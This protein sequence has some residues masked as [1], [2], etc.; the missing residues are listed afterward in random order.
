MQQHGLANAVGGGPE[1]WEK[2]YA[3]SMAR[4]GELQQED[5]YCTCEDLFHFL[6]SHNMWPDQETD[7][8]GAA[9]SSMPSLVVG[10]GTS[11]LPML[12]A[13]REA[14]HCRK[15]A[16]TAIDA[17]S[18]AIK[19]MKQADV[20]DLVDWRVA[21]A[22][23]MEDKWQHCFGMLFDKGLLGSIVAAEA[24]QAAGGEAAIEGGVSPMGLLKEYH[25]VLRP[26][27]RV[28][29][30][31]P[32]MHSQH[33]LEENLTSTSKSTTGGS[34]DWDMLCSRAIGDGVVT[35]ARAVFDF[36]K[37][38]E[39]SLPPLGYPS[40]LC[41]VTEHVE[42]GLVILR[43]SLNKQ[44][45]KLVELDVSAQQPDSNSQQDPPVLIR[46]RHSCDARGVA[47]QL[48]LPAPPRLAKWTARGLEISFHTRHTG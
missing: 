18:T 37:T 1:F 16:V 6:D 46:F 14:E 45:R 27:S 22:S 20:M 8:A 17:A 38:G 3:R 32:D 11:A 10:C 13:G 36:G 30:V 4:V 39:C 12:L 28:V 19:F 15:Y 33:I 9:S 29:F 24:I 7:S 43:T 5:C 23:A 35:V 31:M 47:V 42:E 48:H 44:D 21:D 41:S 25:R 2:R 40:W 26:G 34:T